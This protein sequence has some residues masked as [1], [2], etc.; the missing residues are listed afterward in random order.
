MASTTES[1][2]AASAGVAPSNATAIITSVSPRDV[3]TRLF[4]AR[5][6]ARYASAARSRPSSTAIALADS[7]PPRRRALPPTLSRLSEMRRVARMSPDAND[8]SISSRAA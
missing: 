5:A 1:T 3:G 4:A 7:S 2:R 6:S 8:R